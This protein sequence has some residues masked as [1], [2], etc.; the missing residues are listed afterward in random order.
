MKKGKDLK[1]TTFFGESTEKDVPY[2]LLAEALG[3]WGKQ[4][5]SSNQSVISVQ[6]AQ[7]DLFDSL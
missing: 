3:V 2:F 7:G 5:P 1:A 4:L 6:S